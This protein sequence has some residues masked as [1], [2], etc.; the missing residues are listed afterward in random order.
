[1][2]GQLVLLF[3]LAP[4]GVWHARAITHAPV[5]S[6][7]AISPLP[8]KGRYVFCAT[9]R[10]SPCAAVSSHPALR[11]PDFPL[12]NWFTIGSGRPIHSGA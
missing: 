10:K 9:F 2:S 8:P 11:S 5:G 6:Y 1:M 12:P 3:G 4:D 7:P